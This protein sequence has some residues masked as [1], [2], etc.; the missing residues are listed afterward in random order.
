[1]FKKILRSPITTVLLFVLAVALLLG[2][3][4]GGVR[5]APLTPMSQSY[6]ASMETSSIAIALVE[7]DGE[8][9]GPDASILESL[10]NGKEPFKVGK[11]YSEKLV[12]RNTGSIGTYI[13]VSVY[14]Y[15]R[16]GNGKA[17][18]LDP[19]LIAIK[20]N[21]SDGWTIDTDAST[22]ERTVLYYTN[23]IAPE[24]DTTSFIDSVTI[25]GKIV[26]ML[27]DDQKSYVYDGITFYIDVVADAVQDH[28]GEAAMLSAW[29]KTNAAG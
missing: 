6:R 18:N 12:V 4:I 3:T 19:S 9:L 24:S 8:P 13:R 29:G 20:F 28:S 22:E 5:A 27:N 25:D 26:K 10:A 16:D 1:M 11:T 21:T 14:K 15:W 23:P 17:V 7:N 2:G